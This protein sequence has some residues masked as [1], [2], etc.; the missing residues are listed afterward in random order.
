MDQAEKQLR[1]WDQVDQTNE[2]SKF[3]ISEENWE[4][5]STD[6]L[7]SFEKLSRLLQEYYPISCSF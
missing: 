6:L 4:F 5:A 2:L 7:K 3:V 1:Y